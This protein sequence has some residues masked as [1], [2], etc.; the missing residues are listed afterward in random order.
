[1]TA[2]AISIFLKLASEEAENLGD[3]GRAPSERQ[4]PPVRTSDIETQVEVLFS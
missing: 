1:M 2:N 4:A 3:V